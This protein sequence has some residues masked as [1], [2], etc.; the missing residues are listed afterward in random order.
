[1]ALPSMSITFQCLAGQPDPPLLHAVVD[2]NQRIFGFNESA[3]TLGPFFASHQD[4]VLCL[5][6]DKEILVGFKIGFL[7]EPAVLESW[8][9]GVLPRYRRCGIAGEMM[10]N[11]HAWCRENGVGR[12][13]TVTNADNEAMLALNRRSGFEEV[14]RF[15]NPNQRLKIEHVLRLDRSQGNSIFSNAF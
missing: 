9:G 2:I 13:Q 15:L 8:R 3:E 14:R 7:I 10:R 12:I 1:M 6:W 5:A 4:M 11:Q